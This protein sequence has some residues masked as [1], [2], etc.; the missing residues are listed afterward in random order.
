MII[1]G[2][3]STIMGLGLISFGLLF[4]QFAEVDISGFSAIFVSFGLFTLALGIASLVTSW[5]SLK[6]KSWAWLS[7][8]IIAII[9]MISAISLLATSG[10]WWH[11]VLLIIYG[12]ILYYMF[13][14][15][16]K[17]YFGKAKISSN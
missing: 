11:V 7:T 16:V 12:I 1:S 13:T 8:V 17:S 5:G 15:N 9:S 6:G 2:I 10:F 3:A 4:G 14:P